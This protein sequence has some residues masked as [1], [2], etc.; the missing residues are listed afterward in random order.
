MERLQLKQ[1]EFCFLVPMLMITRIEI[2]Q[3]LNRNALEQFGRPSDHEG[4]RDLIRVY[5]VDGQGIG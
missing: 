5:G 1:C 3:I 4:I 2:G